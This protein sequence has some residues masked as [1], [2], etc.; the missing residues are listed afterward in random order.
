M[1]AMKDWK[2]I[3]SM[4]LDDNPRNGLQRKILVSNKQVSEKST[5]KPW[6]INDSASY[7]LKSCVTRKN[8]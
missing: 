3:I 7:E 1:K 6:S 2:C 5:E 8:S 4:L